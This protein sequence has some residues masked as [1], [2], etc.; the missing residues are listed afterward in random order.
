MPVA[1]FDISWTPYHVGQAAGMA[2]VLI[3]A[4]LVVRRALE[5]GFGARDKAIALFAV[6]AAC[7]IV[8]LGL[9][10]LTGGAEASGPWSTPAGVSMKAG[11]LAGCKHSGAGAGSCKCLFDRISSVPPYDTPR[12]FATL[13]RSVERARQTQDPRALPGAVVTAIQ[14]CGG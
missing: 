11:F 14:V 9:G 10:S 13:I 8:T 2:V 7:A 6:A 5:R 4:L 1:A 3:V 12:G